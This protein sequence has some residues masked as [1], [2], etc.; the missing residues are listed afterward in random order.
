[1]F[2]WTASIHPIA[3]RPVRARTASA[4]SAADDIVIGTHGGFLTAQWDPRVHGERQIGAMQTSL[5]L[6]IHDAGRGYR[7]VAFQPKSPIRGIS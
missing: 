3:H 5:E 4:R 7:S 1:M 2:R 6:P